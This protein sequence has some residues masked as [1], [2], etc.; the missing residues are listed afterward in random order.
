MALSRF[1]SRYGK[2]EEIFSDNATCFRGA[3][4]EMV[5]AKL[6]INRKCAEEFISSTTAWYFNPPGTPHMGGVWERM[7]RSV[8]ESMK[9]LDDGRKL[10]DEILK[11]TVAEAADMINTRP[12]T[13]KPQEPAGEE[14][15]TPNHFL[16]GAVT[17]ADLQVEPVSA[18]EA[19]RNVYKRAQYL[20][21]RMWERWITEYLPTIN[22]RSKW[23]DDK[24]QLSVGDLVFLVDGKIRKNWR[25]GKIVEVFPG[26]DGTIRQVSVRTADEKLHRRGAVNI[27]VMEIVEGKSGTRSNAGCYGP[28]SVTATEPASG[29]SLGR[30]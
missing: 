7:V 8:K 27:A 19:L 3:W 28:G 4:N 13:Y 2:P 18:A 5:K 23:F 29:A 1:A 20:S 16:R 12:L 10:T 11:T 25:R 21:D 24:R 17:S 26:T 22:K 9:A 6:Q 14:A 15:L 30:W